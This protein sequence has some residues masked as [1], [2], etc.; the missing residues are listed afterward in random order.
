MTRLAY[1][2]A[3]LALAA[4]SGATACG[5]NIDAEPSVDG[6]PEPDGRGDGDAGVDGPGGPA[7][8]GDG[9][10]A[11][12]VEECDDDNDVELDGCSNDCRID[13]FA[14]V[15][16]NGTAAQA[17]VY[18][19]GVVIRGAI[20]PASDV[21]VYAFTVATTSDVSIETF[22]E[23]GPGTCHNV[24][25][26]LTLLAGD[27]TTVLASD[28]DGA[29]GRC[30]LIAASTTGAATRLAPGTYYAAV[31]SFEAGRR[32]PSYGVVIRFAAVCGDGVVAGSEQCEGTACSATCQRIA[33]CG[34]GFV[35][36]SET[37]DDRNTSAGDGCSAACA[38][39][40][41]TENEPNGTSAQAGAP[42]T[43]NVLLGGAIAAAGD[44]DVYAIQL[45][46]T[47]DLR[48]ETFDATGPGACAGV[49]TIVTLL[50]SDGTT[51]LI[52]RDQGGLG[53]CS[54]ID[55]RLATDAAARHLPAGT[56][57]VKVE[58][59]QGTTPAYKVLVNFEALCG[60]HDVEGAEECDGA[61]GCAATC[62]RVAACGDGL[63]D[64]PE[65]CDDRN[66][67]AGDGCNAT[68][69]LEVT[70]EVEP[71][72]SP[73]AAGAPLIPAPTAIVRGAIDPRA[74]V[75]YVAFTLT[76]TAD[77][78]IR[79]SGLTVDTCGVDSLVTLYGTDGITPLALNDDASADT[80]C[81]E[82]TSKTEPAARHLPA[83]TYYV[84]FEED[85]GDS[86]VAGYHLSITVD[87]LCGN[88]TV[89]GFEECDGGAGC[90]ATCDRVAV[91]GDGH[92][93]DAEECDDGAT[94]AGDGCSATCAVEAIA[95]IEPNGTPAEA[96]A[97]A[98]IT[99]SAR[100]RGAIGTAGDRDLTKIVLAADSV[101]RFETFTGPQSCGAATTLR[102]LAAGGAELYADDNS[103]VATCSAFTLRLAA[104]TYYAS[105]GG[106]GDTAT[107]D[108]YVL[109][110]DVLAA[111]EGESEA[112]DTRQTA[113]AI[114]GVD[115]VVLG[116]HT[117]PFDVD[118][119]AIT[120]P[121][122]KSLRAEVIEGGA[123]TCEDGG[124]DPFVTLYNAAGV[125]LGENDD[126]GRGT[127][128][129]VDGTGAFPA[130]AYAAHLAAGTYYLAVEASP[131]A[132]DAPDMPAV[133]DYRLVIVIR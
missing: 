53:G 70:S 26:T 113:D 51:V 101:V 80:T 67:T 21:D 94:T 102:L 88:G 36:G 93:D 129:L 108:A 48:V 52:S 7:V 99:G 122:G 76:A 40:S 11:A 39:E 8:C 91:C 6:S 131:V 133:F 15:E 126:D 1:V 118:F 69:G 55:P 96:D 60:D 64:A 27:G 84:S 56:Y 37:C 103:G 41:L 50:G 13:A 49:D 5:D 73:A 114:A 54:R 25:T 20:S 23:N 85:L 62:D 22:D 47:A 65:T 130:D 24:D 77:V 82:I 2:T 28:D 112:N 45:P 89:E 9:V 128:S 72:D 86:R 12:G 90:T 35:D 110:V 31:R 109:H 29:A 46:A 68:C 97:G 42:R 71:N 120:V 100:L 121:A 124:M 106:R 125:A 18:R 63:V 83:G 111:A 105:V 119:F 38:F 33:T 132:L 3:I 14:E 75:D 4:A 16:P 78:T 32:I 115:G 66:T 61:A 116:H 59:A 79:T 57:F 104:G 81:S 44:V 87:A 10:V 19:P 95:E 127:C 17:T 92:V 117:E 107:V 58:A 34:D 123:E 74:E 30:S 98:A 43:P